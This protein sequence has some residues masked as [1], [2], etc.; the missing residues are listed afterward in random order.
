MERFGFAPANPVVLL[1][2]DATRENI[3]SALEHAATHLHGFQSFLFFLSGHFTSGPYGSEPAG[4]YTDRYA[5]VDP[6]WVR[7][8]S[9]SQLH[10][11][12]CRIPAEDKT[13]ILDGGGPEMTKLASASGDYLLYTSASPGQMTRWRV[14]NFADR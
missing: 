1:D 4:G 5:P 14:L 8:I 12:I 3:V 9:G 6:D 10:Q 2:Q 13:V 7:M 11:L